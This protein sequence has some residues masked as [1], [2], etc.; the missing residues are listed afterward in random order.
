[1]LVHFGHSRVVAV[2]DTPETVGVQVGPYQVQAEL[3]R[4][5][6]G[7]VYRVLAV[8][9]RSYALKCLHADTI[10]DP[11]RLQRIGREFE[12]LCR[13]RTPG[14]VR[15][16]D[17][18]WHGKA[19]YLV[20]DLV[21]GGSLQGRIRREGT[22]E[23][24]VAAALCAEVARTLHELH[25]LGMVH[26][27]VKPENVLLDQGAP[28]LT[29]LGLVHFAD[30]HE[31]LT[32]TG[33][34][35][36]TP[37]YC[38]PE[39]LSASSEREA[40][41][42]SIDVYGLGATLYALLT[43]G[44]PFTGASAYEVAVQTVERAPTPLIQHAAVTSRGPQIALLDEIC[45]RCLAKDPG[46]RYASALHLAED[47][48]RVAEEDLEERGFAVLPVALFVVIVAL[49]ATLYVLARP[50]PS[51]VKANPSLAEASGASEGSPTPETSPASE[52][53]L[54]SKANPAS[55]ASPAPTESAPTKANAAPEPS[56]TPDVQVARPVRGPE[57]LG[58]LGIMGAVLWA[59][60]GTTWRLLREPG[61]VVSLTSL[62]NDGSLRYFFRSRGDLGAIEASVTLE[63]PSADAE[64]TAGLVYGQPK[65]R[66]YFVLGLTHKNRAVVYRRDEKGL[67]RRL[68]SGVKP[69]FHSL[70]VKELS[71]GRLAILIDGQQ[72]M[73]LGGQAEPGAQVGLFLIGPGKARFREF[74][75]AAAAER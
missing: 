30:V 19:P 8:D 23:P 63:T 17:S 60:R 25:R 53:R 24:V 20:M 21:E 64:L 69:G 74:R 6:M 55:E 62:R 43:G 75:L 32:Q 39:L 29:D 54:A 52:D 2:E 42:P 61:N 3:G 28:R 22:L 68:S 45:M 9:G 49:L 31:R 13:L 35:L 44:A 26:R 38:A 47:L 56:L 10:S 1:V 51:R 48:E 16:V 18:G 72:R 11:L 46:D 14:V 67:K 57:D 50:K 36:G 33:T 40:P 34:T 66:R 4:G 73:T 58:P 7:V 59:R 37:G 41:G 70:G 71:K 27:D 65:E 12:A 15:V 5:G